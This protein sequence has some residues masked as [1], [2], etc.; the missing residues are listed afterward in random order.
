MKNPNDVL[1]DALHLDEIAD[2]QLMEAPASGDP[3]ELPPQRSEA[4]K[5]TYHPREV[6]DVDIAFPAIGEDL[7][8]TWN[9]IPE[10][11]RSQEHPL[12]KLV[13][14]W[15]FEGLTAP[16]I[17]T[18]PGID[19]EK[20]MRHLSVCLRSYKPKHE[21]KIAGIAYLISLWFEKFEETA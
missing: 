7:L 21:H 17:V 18:K 10:E 20:A 1:N 13:G 15:F 11:F 4:A 9:Y 6:K 14:T 19:C 12:C 3:A 5:R 8:P 2:D 16:E